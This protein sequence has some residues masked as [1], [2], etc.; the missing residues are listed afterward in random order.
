MNTAEVV[1]REVQRQRRVQVLPLRAVGVGQAGQP[2][3]PLTERTVLALN[4]RR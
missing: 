2:L 3:A 4:V 1:V